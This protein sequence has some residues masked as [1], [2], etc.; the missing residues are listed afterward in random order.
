MKGPDDM[1]AEECAAESPLLRAGALRLKRGFDIVAALALM[2]GSLPFAVAIAI[3]IIAETPGPV[4]FRHVRIGR[5]G[6]LFR[7]WKFRSM[8]I[9]ADAALQ[10]YLDRHPELLEEWN[11]THKLKQ[12][13]RVTRVGKWLRRSSLDELP[14]LW[15]VLRGDMSMVGPR[16]I[17][18]AEKVK[19]GSAVSLYLCVPPGLTGLWQI[20]GRTDTSYRRRI[21]LDTEYIR[22][23]SIGLDLWV[24]LKTVRVVLLGHGAY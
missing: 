19:Y 8:R 5:H 1:I 7:L 23:W 3:A 18:E 6:R 13:P 11:E 17:V 9:N 2:A 10:D 15:N 14:Q 24:L 22:R 16:P 20:S 12:D 4:L 21:E